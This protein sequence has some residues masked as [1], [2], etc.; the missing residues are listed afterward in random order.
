M[1]DSELKQFSCS[2]CKRNKHEVQKLI[3]GKTSKGIVNF[4][5]DICTKICYN[6]IVNPEK[7][8]KITLT[9]KKIYE[10]LNKSVEGQDEVKK[11]L[12]TVA[13]NHYKRV[14]FKGDILIEKSNV[15][16]VGKSGSGKTFLVETL[17]KILDV[18]FV[19]IDVT[20]LTESGYVGDDVESI[21][22]KLLSAAKHNLEKAQCGIVFLDEIDKLRKKGSSMDGTM[23]VSG[24]GVQQS[25]LKMIEGTVVSTAAGKK[26]YDQ[27][28]SIDT[29]NILFICAGAF[30]DLQKIISK[31][32]SSSIGLHNKKT[33][34][35]NYDEIMQDL[36][37]D[38]LIKYGIIPEFLGRCPINIVLK[39]LTEK[40]LINILSRPKN[41]ILKQYRE[42]MKIQDG[43]N[44]EWTDEAL[45]EIAKKSLSNKCQSGARGLRS[46]IENILMDI[47]FNIHDLKPNSS[48]I[49][50]KNCVIG[51][52]KPEIVEN[53]K[54]NVKTKTPKVG[55]KK[56]LKI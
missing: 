29:K 19:S 7:E 11:I 46:I 25:L 26:G 35:N 50:T 1:T 40:D 30:D 27:Q 10:E 51:N 55:K 34:E 18:P 41:A 47:N 36:T 9:P 28:V 5:C 31:D 52:S 42:L 4:I 32:T 39:Q 15:L 8:K 37:T 13:Y 21:V 3:A 24:V 45:E 20:T 56:I 23:D 48:V 49:I 12:S 33:N 6:A 53:V 16:M 54:I 43:I 2:F 38:H 22:V 14:N 44:L 17:S